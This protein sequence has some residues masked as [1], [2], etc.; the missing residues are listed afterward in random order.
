MKRSSMVLTTMA[1][2]A[3]SI[4]TRRPSLRSASLACTA[5]ASLG[6][7][8]EAGAQPAPATPQT[9]GGRLTAA[10]SGQT[11]L[12]ASGSYGTLNI[13][14]RK[15][16]GAGLV[17]EAQPGAKPVFTAI[18][19]DSSEGIA[20]KNVEVAI[21]RG[22]PNA[23]VIGVNLNHSAHVSVSGLKVHG[24]PNEEISGNGM[25]M[26]DCTDVSVADSDFR[27]I[28]TGVNYLDSDHVDIL[29]NSFSDIQSDSMRGASSHVN[30]IGNHATNFHPQPGDH[31]DFIQFWSTKETGPSANNVI[32]DNVYV[33]GDG[34][35]VQGVF[36]EDN[37]DIVISGNAMLGVAYNAISLSRTQGAVI[38]D[39]FIQSYPDMGA[40]VITRGASSNVTV[41][42]NVTPAV[43][44][45]AEDG[46]P[47]AGYK[48][49]GNKSIKTATPGDA[50]AMQAWLARREQH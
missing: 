45:Y 25:R 44:N 39:N 2:R 40:R 33:R 37:K 21:E 49:Q 18:N 22:P 19:I 30:V 6:F 11:I 43:I 13:Y 16:S 14:G 1:V 20:V 26:R 15:F 4:A 48:E 42:N 35:P 10:Q 5:L 31:P 23:T 46:K 7:W 34:A 28:G 47:N 24:A 12:L 8:A 17:I 38:E 50:S 27:R 32:K 36:I 9:L 29:R 3:L 41:R